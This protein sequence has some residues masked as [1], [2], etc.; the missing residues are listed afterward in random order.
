LYRTASRDRRRIVDLNC[1]IL[2]GG[3][4]KVRRRP[5]KVTDVVLPPFDTISVPLVFEVL[6]D[7]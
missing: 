7:L 3:D 5:I 4:V 1:A 6:A 2:A